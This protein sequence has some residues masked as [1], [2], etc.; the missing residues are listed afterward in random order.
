MVFYKL[1]VKEHRCLKEVV[2]Q[3]LLSLT[4]YRIIMEQAGNFLS[5]FLNLF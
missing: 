4:K 2:K 3:G 5:D 1:K